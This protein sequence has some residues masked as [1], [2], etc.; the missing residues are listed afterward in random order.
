MGLAPG[1]DTPADAKLKPEQRLD[2]DSC[3][4]GFCGDLTERSILRT[5]AASS[6][7]V[8][9][10]ICMK[11]S[12]AALWGPSSSDAKGIH[13][14]SCNGGAGTGARL[15]T[16]LHTV[17]VPVGDDVVAILMEGDA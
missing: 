16:L 7:A 11:L 5:W 1:Q 3:Y 10:V 13:E 15:G 12:F 17:V 2:L 9:C 6:F 14:K 8:I 4:L